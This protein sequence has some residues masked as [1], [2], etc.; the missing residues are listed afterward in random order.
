[1]EFRLGLASKLVLSCYPLEK[2]M[3]F[4]YHEENAASSFLLRSSLY[5][6]TQMGETCATEKHRKRRRERLGVVKLSITMT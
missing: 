6:F 1:M 5:S 4:D 3:K 2:E